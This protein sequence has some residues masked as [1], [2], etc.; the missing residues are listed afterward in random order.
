M[1]IASA[2]DIVRRY[3]SEAVDQQNLVLL[4]ALWTPDCIVH[5]PEIADPVRG[6]DAFKRAWK[7]AIVDPYSKFTT[8]IHDLIAE[9]DRVSCR[10]SHKAVHRAEWTSR[11]GRHAVPAGKIVRWSSI[12][13]F[14][15]RGG[16]IAEEW[17]CRDELAMLLQLGA[18]TPAGPAL[19]DPVYEAADQEL[20]L[21]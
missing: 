1:S 2:K 4:D 14:R 11:L 15:I 17:V 20:P 12:T 9:G 13:N 10:L 5:R 7:K 8:T 16:K 19:N 18:V 3:F 6:I 21:A